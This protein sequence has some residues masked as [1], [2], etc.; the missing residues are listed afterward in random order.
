MSDI[1][2]SI[3]RELSKPSARDRQR[4][5][6]PSE[7]GDLCEYCLAEKLL[8]IHK[9][10][11][12]HSLAP[13]IG[14]AF[15]LYLEN[16]IGLKG[17][18]KE[19]KV[20]VGT[21]DGYGDISGTCDG[22]DTTTGHVVDYKVLSKKKIKAFSSA[23]FFDEDRNPEFYSDSRTKLQLKKYFYQMMLY[24]LGIE[25]SG[26]EVNYC[27]L[28]LFPRDCT[29][30]SVLQA[31]HEL[32]FKYNRQAALNVLERAN[33]ILKWADKNRDHLE[34]LDSHPGCYYCAFKR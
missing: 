6:G 22:F 26:H 5:V 24:G 11:S 23:T 20:T 16:V 9:E 33:Q 31:S 10:D 7:L 8:G 25:N 18:L 21:I 15:H 1:Y 2:D 27:S 14:T 13:M 32:C 30:E 17:Y 4:K 12:N 3:I 34:D 19:T 29:I 28:I